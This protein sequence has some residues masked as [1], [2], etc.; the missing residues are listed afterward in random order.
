M[1]LDT[2][3]SGRDAFSGRSIRTYQ[4]WLALILIF[5]RL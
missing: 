4:Y 2:D 3:E 5:N 1:D